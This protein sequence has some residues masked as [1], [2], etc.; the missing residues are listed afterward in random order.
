MMRVFAVGLAA[1]LLS[2]SAAPAA[3]QTASVAFTIA[4]PDLI[5]EGIAY[6]P[7]DRAFFVSSTYR[8]KIVRVDEGGRASNFTDEMQ[9][10]LLGVIGMRVDAK[11]RLLWAA[12]SHVGE[13]MPVKNMSALPTNASGL[14]KYDLKTRKLAA[15]IRP[16]EPD[17]PHFLNDVAIGDDG[18][19]YV[20]D[21]MSG[22]IYIVAPQAQAM[23]QCVQLEN[24]RPNGI[25]IS[26]DGKTLFVA[27]YGPGVVK[28]DIASRRQTVL[29]LPAGET[30]A[31]DGLISS[32]AM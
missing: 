10:G 9:D 27:A 30:I 13:G 26:A 23:D 25:D 11:R 29:A 31:A 19:V 22:A 6:D 5:P 15:M 8:R 3:E 24:G 1:A 28:I 14:A 18:T 17:K 4:E 21:T 16:P 20:T 2:A 12:N 7:V 32:R